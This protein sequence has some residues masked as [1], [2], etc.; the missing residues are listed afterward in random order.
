[1]KAVVALGTRPEGIKLAP[2]IKELEISGVETII[3]V[4]GQ[5]RELL[6]QVLDLFSIKPHYNL[7]IMAPNQSL[8]EIHVKVLSGMS[9]VLQEEKPDVVIVQGDTTTALAT[10]I[11]A[12]YQKISIAHVEAGL[13]THD[14]YSP[15]PEEINRKVIDH[16]ADFNFAPTSIA[17]K[18][19]ME[20]GISRE[21]IFL[22]GNT[23]IDALN[24]IVDDSYVFEPP[25]DR[26]DLSRSILVTTHRRENWGEPMK[27]IYTALLAL[28]NRY[29]DVE[30]IFPLHPN[31]IVSSLARHI[32]GGHDRI[33]LIDPLPYR[34]FVNLMSRCY[35][36]MTDSGGV[37]EEASALGKPVIVLRENTERI[38]IIKAG[39]GRLAGT[40]KERIIEEVSRILEDPNEYR[41]MAR[42][43]RIYGDGKA[44]KRIVRI[45]RKRLGRELSYRQI[46]FSPSIYR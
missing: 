19:L 38:E 42:A 25:L 17:R 20:E 45:L 43:R 9:R 28:V 39:I 18:N 8:A 46:S 23:V 11:A 22:T 26:L 6:N 36:V 16:L 21:K 30:I 12:F 32:L 2:V 27:E 24:Q 31:P 40:K 37:Q 44:S 15:F 34:S 41:K 35:L 1:M 3:A 13:R 5:H 33:H 4:S 14:K 29:R 7:D 10:A